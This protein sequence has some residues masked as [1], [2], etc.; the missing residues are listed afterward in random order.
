MDDL[1]ED[2]EEFEEA[3][4]GPDLDF[5]MAALLASTGT[6]SDVQ[7]PLGYVM[8][9]SGVTFEDPI[10]EGESGMIFEGW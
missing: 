5:E 7:L 10:D 9:Q 2:K 1:L 6:Q 4:D 8:D 3:I